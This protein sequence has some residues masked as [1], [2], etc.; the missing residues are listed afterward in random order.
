[1]KQKIFTIEKLQDILEQKK[2]KNLLI[3]IAGASPVPMQRVSRFVQ[4]QKSCASGAA[5][6]CPRGE[7]PPPALP[8]Q[9]DGSGV[10]SPAACSVN[11]SGIVSIAAVGPVAACDTDA[12]G[13]Q[14][15]HHDLE[16]VP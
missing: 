4:S 7:P 15:R 9:H 3:G 12:A 16:R 8:H 14:A 11:L 5:W 2:I 1:M 13:T 10:V 6:T